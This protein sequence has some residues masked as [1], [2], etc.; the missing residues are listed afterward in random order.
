[1]SS[2]ANEKQTKNHWQRKY[3]KY[4][5]IT[6][7]EYRIESNHKNEKT[8]WNGQEI[9]IATHIQNE[10]TGRRR[11][12]KDSLN[13]SRYRSLSSSLSLCPSFL[14]GVRFVRPINFITWWFFIC[15]FLF[16]TFFTFNITGLQHKCQPCVFLFTYLSKLPLVREFISIVRWYFF[17]SSFHFVSF[18]FVVVDSL[19][20]NFDW[21]LSAFEKPSEK[22]LKLIY[23]LLHV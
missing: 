10:Y 1:M 17:F 8:K 14:E 19:Y 15:V 12:S 20:F 2:T 23:S 18:H 21:F 16:F 22:L 7:A 11:C 6:V 5:S 4:A 9:M 13:L 3:N